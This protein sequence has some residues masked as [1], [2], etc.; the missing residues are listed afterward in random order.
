VD[1]LERLYHQGFALLDAHPE[2]V[3]VDE[4]GRLRVFDYE[5]LVAYGDARPARFEESWDVVGPPADFGGDQPAGGCPTW[6]RHW[7]PYVGLTLYE[8]RHDSPPVQHLK[9]ARHWMF[10]FL[11]RRLD[12]RLP[13]GVLKVKWSIGRLARKAF[14]SN[15][16]G[17]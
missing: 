1:F 16:E 2:N 15:G 7:R 10:R 9:R 5:F 6:E 8:L 12:E 17:A 4:D 14:R 3:L 11:P 13:A